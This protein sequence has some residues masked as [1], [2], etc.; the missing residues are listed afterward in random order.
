MTH[1]SHPIH[2]C[3]TTC[4]VHTGVNRSTTNVRFP[5]LS[6]IIHLFVL[7]TRSTDN[8]V[9]FDEFLHYRIP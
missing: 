8:G 7:T 9:L 2:L 4:I 1:G 3:V 6:I 5:L